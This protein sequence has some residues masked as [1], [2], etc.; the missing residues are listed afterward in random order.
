MNGNSPLAA[1]TTLVPVN[2]STPEVTA[3]RKKSV[4]EYAYLLEKEIL[5]DGFGDYKIIVVELGN[6][7]LFRAFFKINDPINVSE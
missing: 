6:R 4:Q 2:E 7:K 5:I 3:K 1:S